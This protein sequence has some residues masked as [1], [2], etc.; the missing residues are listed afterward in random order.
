MRLNAHVAT[1][2]LKC[3]YLGLNANNDKQRL[4]KVGSML[5]ETHLVENN[6]YMSE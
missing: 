3:S 5:R 1:Y 2:A 6:K 4:K